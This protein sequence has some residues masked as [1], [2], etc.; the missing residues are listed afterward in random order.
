[1]LNRGHLIQ[2]KAD[3]ISPNEAVFSQVT[4]F[5]RELKF[6]LALKKKN[7]IFCFFYAFIYNN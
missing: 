3:F 6:D 1:M 2:C 7:Q 5:M 4:V